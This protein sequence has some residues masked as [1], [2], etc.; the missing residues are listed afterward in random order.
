MGPSS[1]ES[2]LH[3]LETPFWIQALPSIHLMSRTGNR[4]Y[5]ILVVD[6][7][8]GLRDLHQ[9]NLEDAG[10]ICFTASNGQDALEVLAVEAIDLAVIDIIM[11]EMS[12]LELFQR[13]KEQYP[14]IAVLFV[15]AVDQMDLAISR[16]KE[17]AYDYLVKPVSRSKLIGAVNEA[18]EKQS[19][20]LENSGHQRHLE[21][22]LV[23]QSKALEN[24][25]RE[26]RALNRMFLK[27]QESRAVLQDGVGIH[28]YQQTSA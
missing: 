5:Q 6:D 7:E 3:G 9:E 2:T 4:N 15:T 20:Y 19:E 21:E 11:P 25:V 28:K 23:H 27:L 13:M 1:A 17:G 26:V 14:W 10:F 24:K 22:L 16:V 18:L 12:G 8:S